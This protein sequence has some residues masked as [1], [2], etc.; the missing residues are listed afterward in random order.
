MSEQPIR[1]PPGLPATE[2]QR[3]FVD[4]LRKRLSL[5]KPLLDNHCVARFGCPLAELDRA[6]LSAL[7][8]EMQGWRAIPAQLARESGQQDLWPTGEV[9]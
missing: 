1:I 6:A 4:G 8:D 2:A 7:I 3:Q 9:G 5:S